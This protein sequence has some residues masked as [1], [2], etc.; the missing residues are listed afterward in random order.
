MLQRCGQWLVAL[1][2]FLSVRRK[3]DRGEIKNGTNYFPAYK[4]RFAQRKNV[5]FLEYAIVISNAIRRMLT[6]LSFVPFFIPLDLFFSLRIKNA[7]GRTGMD[8]LFCAFCMKKMWVKHR[9]CRRGGTKGESR[10]C[11]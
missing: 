1:R 3:K 2:H 8:I 4:N 7:S 10:L 6:F 9:A 5:I 11:A